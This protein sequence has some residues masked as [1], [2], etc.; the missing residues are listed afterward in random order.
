MNPEKRRR[1]EEDLAVAQQIRKKYAKRVFDV[2]SRISRDLS[3]LEAIDEEMREE[4]H[5]HNKNINILHVTYDIA[6]EYDGASYNDA[7]IMI[8]GIID[9]SEEDAKGDAEHI[10]IT[11]ERLQQAKEKKEEE[12]IEE[13]KTKK[14]EEATTTAE[15]P[16]STGEAKN[17]DT[18]TETSNDSS[19]SVPHPPNKADA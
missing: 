7:A 16:L 9:T 4:A 2:A 3:E 15:L 11:E 1:V 14:A 5:T 18:E 12:V 6:G 19:D 17:M 10:K 13:D 8:R